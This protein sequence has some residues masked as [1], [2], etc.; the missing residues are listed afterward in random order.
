MSYSISE[1]QAAIESFDM[2]RA[3]ELLR[4]A[5]KQNPSAD[6]YYLAAQAA[7]NEGQKKVFLEKAVEVDPFHEKAIVEIQQMEKFSTQNSTYKKQQIEL[8][9]DTKVSIKDVELDSSPLKLDGSLNST[10]N[11]TPDISVP[12]SDSPSLQETVS[13]VSVND[14]AK[15]LPPS[16]ESSS[17]KLSNQKIIMAIVVLLVLGIWGNYLLNNRERSTSHYT[18]VVATSRPAYTP[19][20][21]TKYY[22]L[23]ISQRTTL[24]VLLHASD[25]V[26][27]VATGKILV[28]PLLGVYATPDGVNDGEEFFLGGASKT[29]DFRHGALLCSMTTETY[30]HKCGSSYSFTVSGGNDYLEFDIND[31]DQS[32]NSGEFSVT[33]TIVSR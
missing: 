26:S 15:S 7:V 30:W 24:S 9:Q 14:E 23:S 25:Q 10:S 17:P 11:E 27:V 2:E 12:I 31:D 33:I 20:P 6:I 19:T 29:S 13:K 3:R 1:I 21:T 5:L 4:E 16:A 22:S 8:P 32:N 28:S 18:S